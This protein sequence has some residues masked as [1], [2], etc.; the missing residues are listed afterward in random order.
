MARNFVDIAYVEAAGKELLDVT[1]LEIDE[2]YTN[3]EPVSTMSRSRRPLGSTRGQLRV[4]GTLE[5]R[6]RSPREF[7][8]HKRLRSGE[9]FPVAYEEADN[10]ERWLLYDFRVT[11][12]SKSHGED[13]NS[14]ER[15][16]FIALDHVR[17]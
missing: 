14:T 15:I 16:T 7:D 1:R 2:E 8:W 17:E 6:I 5:T 12:I 13:G 4:T 9:H 11:G 10:G 3:A